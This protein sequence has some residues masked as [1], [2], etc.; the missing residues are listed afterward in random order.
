LIDLHCHI[1][2][3][4]DDG[5]LDVE[6]AVGMARQAE[7]DGITTVC[8]TPHIRHDHDVVIGE[9]AHRVGRLN[10]ELG[11]RG[12]GVWIAAGG[13]VAETSVAGLT[14]DELR[15]VSLGGG[16]RWIL[17][18]PAPGALG[19]SLDQAVNGLRERGFRSV[20][21]HPERHIHPGMKRQLSALVQRGALVQVTAAALED[22]HAAPAMLE[23]AGCGL[24]HV[25]GSDAHSSHA[26]R[27]V[28]LS[29]GFSALAGIERVRPHLAWLT[30]EAP[31]AIL[32]G[33][34][35]TAPYGVRV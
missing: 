29:A 7:R 34:E 4:I 35:V 12:I 31:R 9:L 30:D 15:A 18:E 21:A 19:T 16:S 26:G 5:A 24:V 28:S 14:V 22:E 27:P 23:L 32:D 8:A 17:V 25:L 10:A 33:I 3:A 11:R 2:P 1:L 20:I 6:D 13:E